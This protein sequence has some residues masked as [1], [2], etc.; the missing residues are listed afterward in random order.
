MAVS[1]VPPLSFEGNINQHIVSIKT[2]NRHI[3]EVLAAYLN[4][5]IAEALASRR[6]TG[7]TRPAL[8]YPALRSIPIIYDEKILPEIRF[9]YERYNLALD[10]AK[11]KLASIDDYLLD[12][13]GITLPPEP[14]NTIGNRMFRAKRRELVGGRFDPSYF[15]IRFASLISEIKKAGYHLLPVGQV[16]SFLSSGR[17]PA[18]EDYSE[19]PTFYPVI[20]VAS[21]QGDLINLSKTDFAVYPQPYAVRKGDIFVLSAAHQP[22]YVGR[23]V[24]Q[25][26]DEPTQPTSFVGELNIFLPFLVHQPFKHFSIVKNV[27]KHLIYIQMILNT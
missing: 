17:T 6:S 4:T 27:D 25:L 7:G 19:I 21:Y 22:N 10:K 12:A 2:G 14:E 3:S 15:E 8:D 26:D 16:C 9:A 5:D 1:S 11:Q 23:F 20:K 13:L 18:R 24:K